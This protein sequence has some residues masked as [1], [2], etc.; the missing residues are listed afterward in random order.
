MRK[1][2]QVLIYIFVIVLVLSLLFVGFAFPNNN[3]DK[4]Y[5]RNIEKLIID[6]NIYNENN[7]IVYTKTND[8]KEAV[9]KY[10]DGYFNEKGVITIGEDGFFGVVSKFEYLW[11]IRIYTDNLDENNYI[12][13]GSNYRSFAVN[14]KRG[15]IEFEF[16][17]V[18]YYYGGEETT[19]KEHF[20]YFKE[21][22]NIEKIEIL[23]EGL[24]DKFVNFEFVESEYYDGY[25]ISNYTR[26]RIF[27][28]LGINTYFEDYLII[29]NYYKGKPI[30]DYNKD[31]QF[32]N[33]YVKFNSYI[34]T[35]YSET[36]RYCEFFT[37]NKNNSLYTIEDKAFR[38][39][40]MTAFIPENV[41]FFPEDNGGYNY[42]DCLFIFESRRQDIMHYD[43][44]LLDYVEY[45]NVI[46]DNGILYII[47]EFS[48]QAELLRF[49]DCPLSVKIPSSITDK[50]IPVTSI[51]A[52]APFDDDREYIDE[53][54]IP[55]TIKEIEKYFG[56]KFTGL[57]TLVLQEGV[58][59]V[60]D[61]AFSENLS[62]HNITLP[63]S[64]VKIGTQS[65]NISNHNIDDDETFNL[66]YNGTI[67]SWCNLK[68]DYY[69][70]NPLYTFNN[71][72]LKNNAGE[73][74]L[75]T[76]IYIPRT[77]TELDGYH[78]SG[79]KNIDS[80]Y[81]PSNVT[82]ISRKAFY[83]LKNAT[84]YCECEEKPTLWEEGW[85][86][87][88]SVVWGY[89]NEDSAKVAHWELTVE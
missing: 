32:H 73:Y 50:N 45:E 75:V 52:N 68:F 12:T 35:I 36:L 82:K 62:L 80:V 9:F 71:F 58:E 27:Y 74:E 7:D 56:M 78:F 57:K 67:E 40:Q 10:I 16:T 8:G 5:G 44:Y 20:V 34:Q 21:K 41:V 51:F 29:P 18:T 42:Q 86:G 30:I 84:I 6:Q 77:V 66:Y 53:L 39:V 72:Y 28:H 64:L 23:Y 55:G 69:A 61:L 85:E 31:L 89:K 83:L 3:P 15:Y 38:S 26:N 49:I 24:T 33:T 60:G 87:K 48:N 81:I 19:D 76:S 88:C 54:I 2:H 63:K 13:S 79:I 70:D 46:Y 14:K 1:R 65:F 11:K 4:L 22:T 47:D 43:S 37:I 17:N 25:I 59:A